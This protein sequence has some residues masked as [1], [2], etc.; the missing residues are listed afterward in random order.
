MIV[1]TILCWDLHRYCEIK[2]SSLL[3]APEHRSENHWIQVDAKMII[4]VEFVSHG[5]SWRFR[6][7]M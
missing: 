5:C 3:E 2:F 6:G 7:Q 4:Y 1:L